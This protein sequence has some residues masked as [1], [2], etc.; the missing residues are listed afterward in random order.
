LKLLFFF[1]LHSI[2]IKFNMEV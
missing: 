2:G 1:C